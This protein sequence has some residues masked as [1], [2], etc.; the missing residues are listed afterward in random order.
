M[1]AVAT[2]TVQSTATDRLR[3]AFVADTVHGRIGGGITS[4]E[5]F[6]A[7][8]RRTHDV[9]VIGAD[10][11]EGE[12][13]VRLRGFVLPVH[14][15]RTMGFVMAKPDRKAI[16]KAV[17]AADVVHLQFP[18][19]LS[20]VALEEARRAGKPVVAAFHVQPENL[21]YNVGIK[22]AWLCERLYRFWIDHL[23]GRADMV[24][25]PT[26]FAE[27]K[28]RSH[29]LGAPTTVITNGIPTDVIEH[30]K[31]PPPQ[32]ATDADAPFVIMCAGRFAKEKRQADIIEA[33]RRCRNAARIKLVVAG[34]GPDAETVS[35]LAEQLPRRAEVGFFTREELLT[36]LRSAHLFVHAS[37]VELEGI[38]VLEAIGLGVPAL[39]AAGP[40]TAA[41][42]LAIDDRFRF[43]VGDID[44]LAARIDA[45]V[46]S[47][48]ELARAR[49]LYAARVEE[50]DFERSVSKL[51]AV[52]TR[53][54]S[55]S[56]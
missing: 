33:V 2:S 5:R 31:K 49:E 32:P 52:Y 56:G 53:L 13:G 28:L 21:L 55:P 37:E 18:F 51:A 39:V 8:L 44:A 29:G 54:A 40:E 42:E 19:W 26:A 43:P 41:S 23:Y 12:E 9:A 6:V 7:S 4:A 45:L 48:D 22:S 11:D 15:M 47:P 27:Q 30:A 46:E 34:R 1:T 3:V 50:L 16:A 20:F 36:K 10:P 24:V 35:R 14:A 17:A 38:A 25:C